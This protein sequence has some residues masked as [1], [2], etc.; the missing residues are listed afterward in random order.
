MIGCTSSHKFAGT[1]T[2]ANLSEYEALRTVGL[3]AGTDCGTV[4]RLA[5]H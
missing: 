5:R 2:T 4:S 3:A 1:S